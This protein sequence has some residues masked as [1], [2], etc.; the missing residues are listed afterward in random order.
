MQQK[1][2]DIGDVFSDVFDTSNTIIIEIKENEIYLLNENE[3]KNEI[4]FDIVKMRVNVIRYI[5]DSHHQHQKDKNK[6]KN[7]AIHIYARD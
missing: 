3:K 2:N 7:R 1:Q 6:P 5:Q 4:I